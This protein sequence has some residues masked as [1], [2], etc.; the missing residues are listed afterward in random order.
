MT[1]L[2]DM[3]VLSTSDWAA[4]GFAVGRYGVA[5]VHQIEE[6]QAQLTTAR[7]DALLGVA[8][9]IEIAASY[10]NDAVYWDET[11]YH[12][13][14]LSDFVIGKPVPPTSEGNKDD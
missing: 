12:G 8:A 1:D 10:M 6:L 3:K 14:S 2:E 9:R 11:D 7:N 13:Q 4:G 5:A